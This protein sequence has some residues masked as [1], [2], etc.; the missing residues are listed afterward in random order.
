MTDP[1]AAS[2]FLQGEV[3]A[4]G[5]N[6]F[7]AASPSGQPFQMVEITRDADHGLEVRVP[8][9]PPIVPE[10]APAVRAKLREHGFRSEDPSDRTKPWVCPT[11]DAESAVRLLQRLFTEVFGAKPDADI[12]LAHGSHAAEIEAQRK[13]A[14]VRERVEGVLA[15]MAGGQVPDK[16]EDGDYRLPVNDVHV[17]VAPRVTP[18]AAVVVRV[19]AV[20]NVDVTVAPELGLFLA[21]LNF[22]SV[23]GRFALDVENRAIWVDETLLGEHFSD[24]ELRFIVGAVAS[25][26]DQWDDR[27]KQMF[28]GSKYQ[29]VLT[30]RADQ[31]PPAKPGHAGY[32]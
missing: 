18:T 14:A 3:E 30:Q 28:G 11:E 15:E 26:A 23:F 4:L 20:T 32:L 21:R 2:I 13:L 24:E 17:F 1:A 12:D 8:G 31:P 25:I 7:L 16:D 10:L 5:P 19:F 6:A 27:L 22:G 29:E 9:R